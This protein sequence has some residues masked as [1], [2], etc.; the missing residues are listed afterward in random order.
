MM[1]SGI[2]RIYKIIAILMERNLTE[3]TPQESNITPSRHNLFNSELGDAETAFTPSGIE[4]IGVNRMLDAARG[5]PEG[6]VRTYIDLDEF[7]SVAIPAG[8]SDEEVFELHDLISDGVFTFH[9]EREG[10][11]SGTYFLKPDE[12]LDILYAASHKATEQGYG[13]SVQ[14]SKYAHVFIPPALTDQQVKF[15]NRMLFS[16]VQIWR[17]NS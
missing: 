3:N 9:T 6:R 16:G 1:L 2:I 8:M 11:E 13:F 17:K 10:K 12:C 14:L 5:N 4:G 15:L 7:R